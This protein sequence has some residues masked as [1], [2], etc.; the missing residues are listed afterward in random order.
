MDGGGP[1]ASMAGGGGCTAMEVSGPRM[2]CLLGS[3]LALCTKTWTLK[4]FS[5]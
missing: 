4:A 2:C 3:I 5:S 1:G